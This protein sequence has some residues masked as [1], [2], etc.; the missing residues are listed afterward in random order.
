M[1]KFLFTTSTILSI[2]FCSCAQK[3]KLAIY[4]WTYYIPAP[5]LEAFEKEYKTEIIYDEFTSNEEMFAKIKAGGASWDLVFPSSDY[6]SIMIKENMLQKIDKS[7]IP[8]LKNIDSRVLQHITGDPFMEY[9]VPYYWG[10][11]C[12][13]VNKQ[14]VSSFQKDWTLFERSDLFKRMTML[15]DMR[16][17]MG[18]ALLHLGYSVNSKNEKEIEQAANLITQSW[19][20]NLVKFDSASFSK[21]YSLGDFWV[22]QAYPAGVYEEIKDDAALLENTEFFI[23][24][25]GCPA[26]IDSMC[27]L[28]GARNE[29]AAQ[30]FINFIHRPQVYAEFCRA[31]KFPSTVNKEARSL[32]NEKTLYTLDDIFR[33]EV[34]S[35]LGAS[36]SLWSEKWFTAIR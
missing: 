30:S 9:S 12:I 23:P 26:Y 33:L 2:I 3:N 1:N 24:Q 19:K 31:F 13:I 17:V 4:N 35:D 6:V 34:K 5:I 8:N 20:P 29:A 25:S 32:L 36:F 10:A 11:S 16:E 27:I 21:G 14:Y 22:I 18:A 15:D 28:S 7:K